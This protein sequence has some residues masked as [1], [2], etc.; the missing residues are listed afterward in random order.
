MIW[1]MG[2][3]HV[4]FANTTAGLMQEL[5]RRVGATSAVMALFRFVGGALGSS[6]LGLFGVVQTV[7]FSAILIVSAGV[8]IA[9]VLRGQRAAPVV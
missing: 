8:M 3:L 7:G 4:L 2:D 1:L 6:A 5:P 9:L